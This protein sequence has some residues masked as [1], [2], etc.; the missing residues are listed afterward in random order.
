MKIRVNPE[1]VAVAAAGAGVWIASAFLEEY[2]SSYLVGIL[3]YIAIN[4]ILAISLNL[5]S[6][7]TGQF[8]LGHAGFMAVGAYA[9][10]ILEMKVGVPFPIAFLSGGLLAAALGFLVGFP[11]LRLK[12]DYLAIVTLGFNQIIL[13]VLYNMETLAGGAR[14]LPGVPLRTTLPLTL[15]VLFITVWLFRNL[16]E[17]KHGF[18]FRSIRENEIAAESIGINSTYTKVAAF[19]IGSFFAGIA[20]SLLGHYLMYL[21]PDIFSYT[22][23]VEILSMVIFGGLMSITGSILGAAVLTLIPEVFRNLGTILSD[24]GFVALGSFF[25]EGWTV[26]YSLLLIL[27]MLFKP[28]GLFGQQELTAKWLGSFWPGKRSAIGR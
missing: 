13:I 26:I 24:A 28:R 20:G 19:T 4:S 18:F 25:R 10:A 27:T 15:T 6:G 9:S 17:S 7:Y 5:I 22:K 1:W 14:G 11:T 16:L 3:I 21:N 23:S 2:V 12:A 8:A